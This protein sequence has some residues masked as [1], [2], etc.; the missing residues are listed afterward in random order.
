MRILTE[1]R[2]ALMKQYQRLF[3]MED[4]HLK[5]TDGALTAIASEAIRR[6]TGARGLRAIMEEIMLD[7][8]YDLPSRENIKE[9]IISEEVVERKKDPIL[10]Y[11]NEAE[12]A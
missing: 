12:W 9:C 3:E 5:F 10:V 11:E 8:M 7:V 6:K 1:P 4:V 2:N